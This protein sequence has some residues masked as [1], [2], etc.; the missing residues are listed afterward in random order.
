MSPI[1]PHKE[2]RRLRA[3]LRAAEARVAGLVAH[4]RALGAEPFAVAEWT[5]DLRP[6]GV[7]LVSALAAAHPRALDV[8]ALDVAIPRQDHAADRDP[9]IVNVLIHH[10]R[11]ELGR[12]VIENIWGRGYRLSDA[13]AA[14]VKNPAALE[15]SEDSQSPG[16]PGR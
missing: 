6:Q 1:S 16:V 15:N 9:R 7:A 10:V 11:A 13:M 3:D 5:E 2:N 14:R 4:L 12:D 8:H